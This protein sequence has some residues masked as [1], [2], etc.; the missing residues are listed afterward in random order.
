ML[1]AQRVNRYK[2][3]AFKCLKSS[4][5]STPFSEMAQI[6]HHK[7]FSNKSF[8]NMGFLRNL[9]TIDAINFATKSPN[10]SAPT[11]IDVI[12]EKGDV[13]NLISQLEESQALPGAFNSHF[14]KSIL[15]MEELGLWESTIRIIDRFISCDI[16]DQRS[17]EVICDVMS[18]SPY[19][20]KAAVLI[21]DM[22]RNHY[23]PSPEVTK[24]VSKSLRETG[25]ISQLLSMIDVLLEFRFPPSR[26]VYHNV[27]QLCRHR[28]QP[29]VAVKVIEVM[30][31]TLGQDMTQLAYDLALDAA[32]ACN[33]NDVILS[34]L[35][36]LNQR[37]NLRR[38]GLQIECQ[39]A[40]ENLDAVIATIDDAHYMQV[41][42]GYPHYVKAVVA[43][44]EAG[45]NEDINKIFTGII[46][47]RNPDLKVVVAIDTIVKLYFASIV[48]FLHFNSLQ[49]RL[50]RTPLKCGRLW[51]KIGRQN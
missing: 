42:P 45:R 47:F 40:L 3:I 19:P 7:R 30:Q 10:E 13:Q 24:L 51:G 48:Q 23:Q 21:C 36:N 11:N 2:I 25:N 35:E 5:S 16:L 44:K 50:G 4:K 39:L 49:C 31:R 28:H 43:L 46:E 33:R 27:L 9:S 12:A 34:V 32:R 22:A 37:G 1:I 17:W 8:R 15:K 6:S 38:H 29:E 20:V 41:N 14:Q 18:K 26:D